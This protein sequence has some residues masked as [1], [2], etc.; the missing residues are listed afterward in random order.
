MRDC[1]DGQDEVRCHSYT[2]PGFFRCRASTVCVHVSHVCDGILHCPQDDD[3]L[4]CDLRCPVNCTCHGLA[5]RCDGLFLASEYPGLRYVDLT[6]VRMPLQ[7]MT[8]NK[9][10]VFLSLS[11]SGRTSVDRLS[12]TN[13]RTLDLSDND[14]P[15]LNA[16]EL[17]DC[18]NLQILRVAGN[19]LPGHIISDMTVRDFKSIVTLDVSR[20][21]LEHFNVSVLSGFRNLQSLNLSGSRIHFLGEGFS[22]LTKLRTLDLRDCP[23]SS[24]PRDVYRGLSSLAKVYSDDFKLCCAAILPGGFNTDGCNAPSD[25]VSS[26]SNL[27]GRNHNRVLL[28]TF[29]TLS[30]IGN[31]IRFMIQIMKRTTVQKTNIGLFLLHLTV[32]DFLMGLYLAVIVVADRLFD[33]N[34]LW[35]DVDFRH[36]GVCR[37]SG[38]VFVLAG[39]VSSF[40]T[41][42]LTHHSS[43]N[44]Y[45]KSS[46]VQVN[47]HACHVVA[48]VIWCTGMVLAAVP[49]LPSYS[50][51][52]FFSQSG[53]CIPVPESSLTSLGHDYR[54]GVLVIL[55]LVLSSLSFIAH[56]L[57]LFALKT[58]TVTT[59]DP[60]GTCPSMRRARR[61]FWLTLTQCLCRF[62]FAVTELSF[63]RDGSISKQMRTTVLT[64]LMSVSSAVNP[65]L[66]ALGV[67]RE[68]RRCEERERLMKQLKG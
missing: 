8:S 12:F 30:I 42:T 49:L 47:V 31:G 55:N 16:E 60:T 39:I 68:R 27:L 57:T 29:A 33:G 19:P 44:L 24:Y 37:L 38:F 51:W 56:G 5:F 32:C 36:S 4:L 63:S 7:N 48:G 46:L 43:W 22:P 1:S 41:S 58:Y 67:V 45:L 26:C 25:V 15:S 34:Y 20:V 61:V 52:R 50:S 64:I 13:L 23:L 54:V 40:L 18:K 21:R 35:H 14:I 2:C 28:S 59:E 9:L 66:Y 17:R 53:L 65:F 10:L 6:G 11:S 3:E 62:F